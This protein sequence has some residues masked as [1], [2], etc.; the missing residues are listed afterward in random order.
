MYKLNFLILFIFLFSCS[1]DNNISDQNETSVK[2]R[3]SVT[4]SYKPTVSGDVSDNVFGG[5]L[6]FTDTT[7]FK[8]FYLEAR[9]YLNEDFSVVRE[10][11]DAPN[12]VSIETL[13]DNDEF[14][15]P[16]NSYKPFLADPIMREICNQYYE[17]QIGD[18]LIT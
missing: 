16:A 4:S 14:D 6:V 13:I 11:I 5:V 18:M 3:S 8:N 7:Q 17:F 15:I 9:S 12:F 2:A 1:K 10:L